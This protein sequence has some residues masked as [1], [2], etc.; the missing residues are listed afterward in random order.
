MSRH[1]LD[2][3]DDNIF[4]V[5]DRDDENQIKIWLEGHIIE[6]DYHLVYDET[7]TPTHSVLAIMFDRMSDATLFKLAWDV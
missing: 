5:K 6:K 2:Q 7:Y 4:I 1:K 3:M